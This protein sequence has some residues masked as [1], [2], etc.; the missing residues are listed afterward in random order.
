MS[1]SGSDKKAQRSLTNPLE[2][3]TVKFQHVIRN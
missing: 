1:N 3:K 2:A